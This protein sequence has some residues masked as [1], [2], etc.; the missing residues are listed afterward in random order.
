MTLAVPGEVA[1]G[2][3]NSG[4][5]RLVGLGQV[6][7]FGDVSLRDDLEGEVCSQETVNMIWVLCS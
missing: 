6:P 5:E 7:E 2:G 3:Q 1:V 4:F